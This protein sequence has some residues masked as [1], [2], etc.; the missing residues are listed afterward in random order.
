MHQPHRTHAP[1]VPA[2]DEAPGTD[3]HVYRRVEAVHG[4][5]QPLGEPHLPVDLEVARVGLDE[6]LVERRRVTHV[7][8][9][10]GRVVGGSKM[11]FA[12]ASGQVDDVQP[13]PSVE[14]G[15][16][17]IGVHRGAA[18]RQVVEAAG[19]VVIAGFIP[20]TRAAGQQVLDHRLHH[21]ALGQDPAEE[22]QDE[23]NIGA[24]RLVRLARAGNGLAQEH[25]QRLGRVEGPVLRATLP[26]DA[27]LLVEGKQA[28][29]QVHVTAN[30]LRP[31]G[32][33]E[34]GVVLAVAVL[35]KAAIRVVEQQALAV[36]VQ[37]IGIPPADHLI[38]RRGVLEREA[39]A[40]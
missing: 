28:A 9:P 33:I 38:K 35:V 6:Q 15:L 16:A 18:A 7:D 24:G 22:V 31:A 19:E 5:E 32:Q 8:Y 14:H 20:Q 25:L 21:L 34:D 17:Q 26:P 39:A 27:A 3:H 12:L 23:G 36:G 40:R 11:Q 2:G 4:A 1:R 10:K 37:Q 30:I 13:P 29:E